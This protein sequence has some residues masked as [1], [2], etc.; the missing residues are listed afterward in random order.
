MNEADAQHM[1]LAEDMRIAV[2]ADW[3]QLSYAE[4]GV[5][6]GAALFVFHDTPGS[7]LQQHPDHSL[8]FASD[9]HLIHPD[10]PGCGMS[11]PQAARDFGDW[12]RDVAQLADQLHVQ[13]FAI[14]AIGGGAPFALA[15]AAHLPERVTRVALASSYVPPQLLGGAYWRLRLKFLLARRWP[16]LLR[17]ALKKDSYRARN[18]I[19]QYLRRLASHLGPHD[20]AVLADPALRAQYEQ[21]AREAFRQS[22]RGLRADLRLLAHPWDIPLQQI[23]ADTAFWHGAEDRIVPVASARALA[24]QLPQAA[25]HEIP[26]AGHLLW[27]AQWPAMLKFLRG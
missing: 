22:T 2:L 8:A 6:E 18:D 9:F 27:T 23:R 1:L 13:R 12:A 20:A 5:A 19:E 25:F 21:D 26:A 7:R 15:C 4:R 16:G 17:A 24:A 11:T 3:R 10:R 14:A